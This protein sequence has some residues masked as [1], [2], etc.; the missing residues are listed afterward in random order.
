M[1]LPGTRDG[2]AT[3]YRCVRPS[4]PAQGDDHRPDVMLKLGDMGF[5]MR[6]R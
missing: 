2:V 6:H 4:A 3:A 5:A 1:R